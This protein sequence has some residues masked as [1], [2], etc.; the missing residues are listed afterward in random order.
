MPMSRDEFVA[1]AN[2]CGVSKKTVDVILRY[3]ASEENYPDEYERT[4]MM[5]GPVKDFDT[6]YNQTLFNLTK[7]SPLEAGFLIV[8]SCGNGDPVAVDI[9]NDVDSVW[10]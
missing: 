1:W 5:I 4:M 9:R 8:G 6:I 2:E 3:H 10:Y 7:V